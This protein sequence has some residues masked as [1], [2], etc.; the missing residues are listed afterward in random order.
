MER[1]VLEIE[2]IIQQDPGNRGLDYWAIQGELHPA[3]Q[4][5]SEGKHILIATGFYIVAADV[6]ETD[7]PPGAIILGETLKRAGKDV[8]LICDDHSESI[9]REGMKT[10]DSNVHLAVI[11]PEGESGLNSLL[12]DNTTHF[13]S[14][15]RPGRASDGGYY[16][17]RG[18]DISQYHHILDDF[19]LDCANRDITTIGIGDG[20]NELGMGKVSSRVD[21][22]I[23]E[24]RP[25][26]CKTE[27]EYAIC[28][29]VSNWAGYAMAAIVSHL[30]GKKLMPDPEK[31]EALLEAI[32]DAGAVDGVS[33]KQEPTVDGLG[34]F[35]EHGIYR[36]L[37]N[38]SSY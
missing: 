8:T 26:S 1:L 27:A 16:N 17:F 37:Y 23:S 25:F 18:S 22:F 19:F 3:I 35:W 11:P 38:L 34:K 28:A 32:V 6:I 24:N 4:S 31:L 13:I 33:G 10:L 30:S 21:Q 9:L 15:E 14:L 5:I 2:R 20:G 7:G 36:E 12:N 29:G